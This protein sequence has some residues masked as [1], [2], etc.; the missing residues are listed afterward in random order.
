MIHATVKK[1]QRTRSGN[2]LITSKN[3]CTPSKSHLTSSGNHLT[4][5]ENLP[6][7]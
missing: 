2:R 7:A 3:D 1:K 6:A 4:V 5:S